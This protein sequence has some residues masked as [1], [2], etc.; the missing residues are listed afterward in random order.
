MHEILNKYTN[1]EQVL[2]KAGSKVI[3][4]LAW[5]KQMNAD[6]N[7]DNRII[8]R[9]SQSHATSNINK[10]K[11]NRYESQQNYR[12]GTVCNKL[13]QGT[14]HINGCSVCMITI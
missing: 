14:K 2:R 9:W 10:H 7:A 3:T 1:M 8:T 12:L 13:P 5:T 6:D 11:S 4:V